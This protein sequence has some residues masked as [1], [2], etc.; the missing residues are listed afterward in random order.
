[1]AAILS[2][3]YTPAYSGCH[4][5]CFKTSQASY[6]CYQD[7]SP[8][9]PG[10]QKITDIDLDDYAECLVDL[11]LEVGCEGGSNVDGYVQPCCTDAVSLENRVPFTAVFSTVPC[12]SYRVECEES[13]VGEIQIIN[14][15]YGWPIGV[16]PNIIVNTTGSGSGFVATATMNCL[17]GDNFCSIDDIDI[18]DPGLEYFYINQLSVSVSPLPPCVS[19]ELITN[20]D[21]SD[22]LNN[23]TI[24][25]QSDRWVLAGAQAGYNNTSYAGVVP[26][27]TLSQNILTPGKTYN[28]N[29]NNVTLGCTGG[30]VELI[31]TAGTFNILGTG[32]NQYKITQPAGPILSTSI[33]VTLT[34]IGTSEFSIYGFA[35]GA[36]SSP[37]DRIRVDNISVVEICT[38]VNPELE[39]GFLDDCGTFT[40]PQCNGDSNP[41]QYDIFGTPEYAINV[42]SGGAGPIA[43][44]GGKYNIT[45]NPPGVSCC[46]CIEYNI[47][48]RNPIDI[49]YT[50]CDQ[51]IVT[52]SVEAGAA[53]L[54]ICG[55]LDSIFPVI[56]T[57]NSEILAITNLGS[58]P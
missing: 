1:M 3:T 2:V 38:P 35:D 40:V 55:V 13:G 27:G 39:I 34:C 17:P 54:T 52:A 8:S 32:P 9:Q 56:K 14:A 10:T 45:P 51:N 18:T 25:P 41:T 7:N 30:F 21:F 12:N 4:R 23:W 50:D 58:C 15:G 33:S 20:G 44:V 42:C 37:L 47:V 36:S 29:I 57:D 31:V 53:G 49:Y 6:C 46:D 24:G 43:G 26:G 16:T 11:P 5:I 19:N 28:I 48:V 22:G